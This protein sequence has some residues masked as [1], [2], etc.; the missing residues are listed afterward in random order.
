MRVK[1]KARESYDRLDDENIEAM[2]E[3]KAESAFVAPSPPP[4]YVPIKT[5]ATDSGDELVDVEVE[6]MLEMKEER[7]N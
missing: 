7:S 3:I 5:D 2:L 1:T 4:T 6:V